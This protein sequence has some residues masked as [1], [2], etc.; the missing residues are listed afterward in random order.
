MSDEEAA[1]SIEYALL[2]GIVVLAIVGVATTLIGP[3][4]A[5]IFVKA[6][7]EFPTAS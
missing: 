5:A 1:A 3:R 6:D 2:L 4:V 7:T